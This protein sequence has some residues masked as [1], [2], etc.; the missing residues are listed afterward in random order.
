M[1]TKS[2]RR[3]EPSCLSRLLSYLVPVSPVP[4][5][6]TS[7]TF[8]P[9]PW[10]P[11]LPPPRPPYMLFSQ[12]APLSLPYF[13][14]IVLIPLPAHVPPS[15]ELCKFPGLKKLAVPSSIQDLNSATRD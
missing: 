15:R 14:W 9:V 4:D 12:I 3:P 1:K 10:T 11:H 6:L 13:G 2:H 8:F 5:A 7:L